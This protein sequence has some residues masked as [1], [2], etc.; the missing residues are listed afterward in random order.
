MRRTIALCWV[1][2]VAVLTASCGSNAPVALPESG[3]TLEGTV[4]QGNEQVM[5]ALIIVEGAGSTATGKVNP[6]TG[7]Y[8]VPNAPLGPVKLA[9]NTDAA[10]GDYRTAMMQAGQYKGPDGKGTGRVNLKHVTVPKKYHD[11]KTSGFT[12]TVEGGTNTHNIVIPK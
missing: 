1:A 12:F 7:K 4:M 10:E 6:E 2:L 5:F 9:V 3:A 11:T 8:V